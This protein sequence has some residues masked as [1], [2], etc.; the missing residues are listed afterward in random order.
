MATENTSNENQQNIKQPLSPLVSIFLKLNVTIAGVIAFVF[1]YFWSGL[2]DFPDKTIADIYALTFVDSEMTIR[3]CVEALTV[4][5]IAV[6]VASILYKAAKRWVY[7]V[8]FII[9]TYAIVIFVGY[10]LYAGQRGF[11]D[12]FSLFTGG[13]DRKT[14]R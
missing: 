3:L 11:Y 13:F 12:V 9:C 14:D 10:A 7:P 2:R 8:W 1:G 4:P 6:A 5:L